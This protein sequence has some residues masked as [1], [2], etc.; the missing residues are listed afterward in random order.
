MVEK[1]RWGILGTGNIA[2]KF[3]GGLTVVDDAELV[4]V[5][6]R[7]Q[8]GADKFGDEFGVPRRHASY[9]ALANDSDIDAV[10]VSTPHPFHK[11]NTILCLKAGKAVICEKPFALNEREAQEMID[12]ATAK[13]VFVMEAMWTRFTPAMVKLRELLAQNVIGEVRM[14][15]ADFGFRTE[16]N[17]QGRLFDLALGGGALLDVGIYPLSFASM[18]LGT[19]SKVV[20]AVAMA[21][22]GADEQNAVLFQYPAG[23]IAIL[24]SASL[25][26]TPNEARIMGTNGSIYIP[27]R[28]WMPQSFTVSV[29]GQA[30]QV[31]E[32]PFTGNGY[33]YEAIEVGRCLRSG[34][35][36]SPTMTHAETLSLMRIMDGIRAEWKLVYPTEKS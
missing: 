10:Y 7:T 17:P 13:G 12:V 29:N 30:D 28:F 5:G 33:N 25:T 1:I 4:A 2:H 9:E 21:P 15:S 32:L 18:V 34:A 16:M 19:P 3:A 35:L 31:Y 8:A 20:S 36:E 22:T 23:Q 24:S 27:S 26:S 11:D 6:S 14:V